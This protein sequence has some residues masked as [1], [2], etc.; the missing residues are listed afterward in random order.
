MELERPKCIKITYLYHP[1]DANAYETLQKYLVG[2]TRA[3]LIEELLDSRA[4][5]NVQ[6][7]MEF[8]LKEAQV[9][10]LLI[11]SNFDADDS[12]S[13]TEMV[14][15]VEQCAEKGANIWPIIVKSVYWKTSA[16]RK[17]EIFFGDDKPITSYQYQDD[18]YTR[19]TEKIDREVTQMLSEEWVQ[20]GDKYRHQ[21]RLEEALMAYNKSLYYTP[22]YP[23]ALLGKGHTFCKQNKPEDALQQYERILSQGMSIQQRG[24]DTS[25]SN[26]QRAYLMHAYCK[27]RTFLE[28]GRVSEARTAFQEVYQRIAS[29]MNGTQRKLCA[30]A[31][32]GE[33]D[34]FLKQGHQAS[35]FS[36]YY[37]QALTAYHKAREFNLENPTYLA[38]IGGAYIALGNRSQSNDCYEKALEIYKQTINCY[39]HYAPAFVGQ[40]NVHYLSHRLNEALCAYEMAI[41]FDPYEAHAYGGKGYALLATKNLQGALSAFEQAL[42]LEHSNAH[43][44]YGKGRVLALLGLHQEALETYENACNY[45]LRQSADFLVH[46]AI[47]L[48]ALGDAECTYGQHA[49]AACYYT[50]ALDSY[51]H[52]LIGGGNEKD[53]CY[54]FGKIHF[55]QKNWNAALIWY[56]RAVSRAPYMAEA[57][58]EEGKTYV[59]LE[60]DKE[61]FDCFISARKYCQHA[62]SMIDEA[63]IETAYGD[64]Y[65]RIA[66]R[67]NPKNY[68]ELLGRARDSYEKATC[69]REHTMAYIGLGKVCAALH[70]DKEAIDALGRAL[71]LKPQLAECYYIKGN[72]YYELGQPSEAYDMYK[73]AIASGF[74]NVSLQKA[75]GRVLLLMKRYQ[76]AV[77][78]FNDIIEH[79]REEAGYAYY[80]RGI[81]LHGLGTNEDALRSFRKAHDID[82]SICWQSQY[83]NILQDIY[84]FFTRKLFNKSQEASTYKCKGDALLLLGERTEEAVGAYTMAIAYGDISADTYCCRGLAYERLHDYQ[85]SLNDYSEAL[86]IDPGNQW[87]Q[88]RKEYVASMIIQLRRGLLKRFASWLTTFSS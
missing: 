5:A 66:E 68:Y 88:Q 87:A 71:E 1:F 82:P 76:E 13:G 78:V 62:E 28:L 7:K 48:M 22:D 79:T 17:H 30:E 74:N 11:S 59:E 27:G 26:S 56:N 18:A 45:G 81:A 67:S 32:C 69:I 60:N 24:K 64:A 20:D 51:Q 36:T 39:P 21:M 49:Q 37:D 55:A 9:I 3:G 23:P 35:D 25:P 10:I 29:P 2:L 31:Y 16:F 52:A 47:T 46:Y 72:C 84:F 75:L 43:Y 53:I 34:T 54:G 83:R 40:G 15:Y 77:E 38:M 80:H 73:T 70:Y 6:E 8:R 63:D 85:S 65:C 19:I 41:Q 33:G 61:A 14:A 4:G 58:L 57:Y 44:Q 42:V 12:Y 86:C 50:K